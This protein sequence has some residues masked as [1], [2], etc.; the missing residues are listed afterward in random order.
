VRD[1][2]EHAAP[3]QHAGHQL[4]EDGGLPDSLGELTEQLGGDEDGGQGQEV[5]GRR[6]AL[7]KLVTNIVEGAQ[8]Q[9]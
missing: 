6:K 8:S 5:E 7:D 1:D 3:Q 4:A 2:A 9:W